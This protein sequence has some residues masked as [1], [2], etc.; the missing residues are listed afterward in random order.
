MNLVPAIKEIERQ[1]NEIKNKHQNELQPYIDSL[2][3]LREINT[4]CENCGGSGKVY[5]RACAEDDGDYYFCDDCRRT[6]L[7]RNTKKECA[8]D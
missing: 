2:K 8:D 5:S 6:G 7:Q 4:T 3:S 1:I